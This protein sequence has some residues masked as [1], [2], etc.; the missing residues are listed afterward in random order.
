MSVLDNSTL[1][2]VGTLEVLFL[3][4]G[5]LDNSTLLSVGTLEVLFLSRGI[6]CILD[7]CL[8]KSSQ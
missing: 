1:L 8:N 2:S 6:F 4:R 3:S 5:I 7:S